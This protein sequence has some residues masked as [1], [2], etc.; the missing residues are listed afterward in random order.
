MG[1]KSSSKGSTT[2][3]Y[4][5]D[6]RIAATDQAVVLT[7]GSVFTVNSIDPGLIDLAK[8][9]GVTSI[10]ENSAIAKLALA[11]ADTLSTKAL[12]AIGSNADKAFQFVD[13]QRT[14]EQERTLRTLMP[15]L[16]GGASV[17]AIVIATRGK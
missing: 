10:T 1:G 6:N 15:W 17:V 13:N 16:I 14:D 9:I 3:T 4:N 2:Q 5:Y 8:D 7:G 12:A 11:N